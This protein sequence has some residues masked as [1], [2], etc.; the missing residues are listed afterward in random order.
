MPEMFDTDASWAK[1]EVEARQAVSLRYNDNLFQYK[2][3]HFVSD[4]TATI[5]AAWQD[6]VKNIIKLYARVVFAAR[7]LY[8]RAESPLLLTSYFRRS[9]NTDRYEIGGYTANI[10]K[11]ATRPADIIYVL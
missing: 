11:S 10:T 3:R 7:S 9:Y 6:I 8:W 5:C 1:S 4:A 2:H